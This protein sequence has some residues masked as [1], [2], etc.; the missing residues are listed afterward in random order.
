ML[1]AISL[2]GIAKSL[3]VIAM[4]AYAE[5]LGRRD[6]R[7]RPGAR[8]PSADFTSLGSFVTKPDSPSTSSG[9]GHAKALLADRAT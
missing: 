2:G 7:Y 8:P 5:L 4:A 1:P 6:A 9:H 3:I